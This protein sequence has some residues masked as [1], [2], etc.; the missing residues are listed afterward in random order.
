MKQL[1]SFLL[2]CLIVFSSSSL[3]AQQSAEPNDDSANIRYIS[4]DLFTY[5]RAGPSSEFR[6]LG[7]VSAG[8]EVRLLQVDR[9]AGY[10]EIIDDRQRTGWVEMKFVSRNPSIRLALK[11]KE[12]EVDELQVRIDELT[13]E[14]SAINGNLAISKEQKVDLNRQITAHLEEIND[15][16]VR[17]SEKDKAD[18]MEWFTRGTILALIS[19]NVGFIMGLF[20]RKRR[21]KERLM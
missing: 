12:R 14:I 10:V 9:A 11:D 1:L 5:M 19:A 20:G 21:T 15:L 3:F 17:I 13:A 18:K 7:S 2:I 16:K 4:D 6:L 8:T